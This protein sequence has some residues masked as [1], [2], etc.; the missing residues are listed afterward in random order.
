M[1]PDDGTAGSRPAERPS[2]RLHRLLHEH[3]PALNRLAAGYEWDPVERQDLLQ[4]IALAIWRALPAFRGDSSERTFVFRIAHNRGL[5]HRWQRRRHATDL[6]AADQIPDHQS[7]PEAALAAQDRQER[8]AAAIRRLPDA[9][10]AAVLLLLE[11]LSQREVGEV[12]GVDENAV[13][14]RL[15]RARKHLRVLLGEEDR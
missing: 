4:E 9:Q 8:L 5:T 15:S 6:A 2:D 14:A 1:A 7:G 10:R 12:L 13:A 11:G 3:G